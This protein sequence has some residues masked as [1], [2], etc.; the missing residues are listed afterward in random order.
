MSDDGRQDTAD[1][2]S[3]NTSPLPGMRVRLSTDPGRVGVFTG[4]ERERAGRKLFQVQFPEGAEYVPDDHLEPVKE[5]GD[6]PVDL[7]ERAKFG[8]PI[9]LRR[10]LTHTKL[11]GRL[12]NVIYS[13]DTTATDFYAYQ[14]KPLVKLLNSATN[15]ILI[16][17]EVGLGKTI[18]AGL[19]WTELRARFDYQR[20]L[21][22]CPAVLRDKWQRELLKRFG[23]EAEKLDAAGVVERLQLA[24]ADPDGARFAVIASLQGVRPPRGWDQNEG[25]SDVSSALTLARL[26]SEQ[27]Q[28]SPIVDLVIIDEAH[29]LRNPETM[30]AAVGRLFRG[31]SAYVLLLSATPV[32][33]RSQ[34]LFQLAN[35]VDPDTYT[36]L[37]AFD[38]LLAAN[39]SLVEARELVLSGRATAGALRS[40][41]LKASEDPVLRGSKQLETALSS[42]PDDSALREPQAISELAWRLENIN[43]LGHV[44]T[45]TRKRHVTELRVVRRAIAEPVPLSRV[46]RDF[47][48]AVT[49]VVREYCARSMAHEGFLL[50][51]P[52]RQMSSSMPAALR[53][54]QE[55]HETNPEQMFEDLGSENQ[56]QDTVLGP[57][58]QALVSRARSLGDYNTLCQNDSKYARLRDRL[59]EFFVQYSDEKVV[60]FSY[61]R[62]TLRY[63]KTRLREEGLKVVLL[64]GGIKDK[65]AALEEFQNA[66]GQTVLLSSEVGSEGIDLQF[67][68][69]VINYDLPWNPMRVEQRIGRLDRLGQKSEKVSIWNL[70]YEDTIDAR[71]YRRLYERLNL[72][73][74]AL[75]GL[76]PILGEEIQ[77]LTTA[78]LSQKLTPAEETER[79][80]QTRIALENTRGEEERLEE[81]ASQLVAYGD[82]IVN[83]VKAARELSR[84]IEG[85]DLSFYVVDFFRMNYPDCEFIQTSDS[86]DFDITLSSKAKFDLQNFLRE[87][88]LR[89]NTRL[90]RADAKAVPCRFDNT[91]VTSKPAKAEIINQV[92]PI[93]RFVGERMRETADALRPAVAVKLAR[94]TEPS[95]LLAGTYL[96]SVQ[97][98]SIRGIQDTDYLYHAATALEDPARHL[99]ADDAE[100]LVTAVATGGTEWFSVENDVDLESA[101]AALQ[102]YCL[103]SSDEAFTRRASELKAQN[104]DRVQIQ[105]RTLDRHFELQQKALQEVLRRHLS[106][107]RTGLVRATEGRLRALS[108]RV[109]LRRQEIEERRILKASQRE[110][111][112]GIVR[113]E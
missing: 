83:Q 101:L 88:R 23:I 43:L 47:Y 11:T 35:L 52:Q 106:L 24:A 39:A 99:S 49:E 44:V 37:Q 1:P 104:Q 93:T 53:S 113:V 61:F 25:E 10:T 29:Y 91:V 87:R 102:D 2:S 65:D 27:Q 67:C 45:R 107:G 41:L 109:A 54:W 34:D 22:L 14:F 110:I 16:A 32:H 8:D 70:F 50:V 19:I 12:A 62:P 15:G 56:D 72:F 100:R 71:I 78:L 63:L 20:L 80:D 105:E 51:M 90:A 26:L 77:K 4:K 76:E 94:T 86:L 103:T 111:A 89:E 31:I 81:E 79:I 28:E 42:I 6:D 98:W 40:R 55:R 95:D 97:H 36:G 17:D 60:I 3:G 48:E 30:T 73:E 66:S 7:F 59:K 33:L 68:W 82:Y 18:E 112:V 21:V 92:H 84:K 64:H 69:L 75:G 9:D 57:L 13:M 38:D 108:E 74:R 96:F 5:G 46:E 58:T 85:T